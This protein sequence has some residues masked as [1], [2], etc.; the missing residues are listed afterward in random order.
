MGKLSFFFGEA[1]GSLRRNYFMTIAALVTVFLSVFV[2]GLTLILVYT[3]DEVMENV[4]DELVISV[5]FNRDPDP[6]TEEMTALQNEILQWPEVRECDFISKQEGLEELKTS[7]EDSPALFESLVKNP[8]PH[9]LEVR[10]VDPLT[11]E[12]VAQ[13]IET[14]ASEGLLDNDPETGEGGVVIDEDVAQKLSAVTSNVRNIM[15]GFIALLGIIAVVLISNTIRLSIFARKREVEIMKLVGA[16]NWFIRWP[17]VIEGVSVGLVGAGF[18]TAVLL[19]L[20]AFAVGKL[21]QV[22]SFLVVPDAVPNL[23][24]A[25]ILLGV[26]VSIGAIGAGLGLRRLLKV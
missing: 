4:E 12:D 19:P 8:L 20:N 14:T 1:F 3:A 22:M 17:F 6:T 11:W 24:V 18:A 21:E 5:Y 10:L 25:L 13:R 2:L 26:G 16:T 23:T 15:V 7:L 9:K